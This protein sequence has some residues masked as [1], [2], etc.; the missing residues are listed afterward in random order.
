MTTTQFQGASPEAQF[1]QM[2]FGQNLRRLQEASSLGV[3]RVIQGELGDIWEECHQ[4]NWDGYDAFPVTSDTYYQVEKFLRAIPRG[5]P[6]PSIGA[7]PDGH[8]ALEWY[9][10]PHRTL[11]VS[12]SPDQELNF[13]ALLGSDKICGSTPFFGEVPKRILD[14]IEQV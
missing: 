13:A 8:I 4:E 12:I 2:Q 7:E 11:S 10:S 5:V 6:M 9:R 1:V 14:L 3:E